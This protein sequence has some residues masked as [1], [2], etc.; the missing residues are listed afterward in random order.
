MTLLNNATPSQSAST[1]F[2]CQSDMHHDTSVIQRAP[3]PY[4]WLATMHSL[5]ACTQMSPLKIES[6]G[7]NYLTHAKNLKS[8][9]SMTNRMCQDYVYI[10]WEYWSTMWKIK[11]YLRHENKVN[12]NKV[13]SY[14]GAL[15][16]EAI[17]SNKKVCFPLCQ[18]YKPTIIL[19]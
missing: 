8:Y 5:Q 15:R 1:S 17:K 10:K 6:P 14:C 4:W 9:R 2:Y 11:H 12:E 16:C 3:L 18:T 19:N 7:D 13:L